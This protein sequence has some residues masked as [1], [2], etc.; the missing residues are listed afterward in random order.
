MNINPY[1]LLAAL[2]LSLIVYYLAKRYQWEK[3]IAYH[4]SIAIIGLIGLTIF[5]YMLIQHF[6]M[7]YLLINIVIF[8]GIVLK[9]LKIIMIKKGKE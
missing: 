9:L 1:I 2:V 6:S 4:A 8:M 7:A 5:T 3:K